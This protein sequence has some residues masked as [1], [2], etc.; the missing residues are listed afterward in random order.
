V[1]QQND[2]GGGGGRIK[3]GSRWDGLEVPGREVRRR[4]ES[5]GGVM[6][7]KGVGARRKKP[8]RDGDEANPS[9]EANARSAK[10]VK[11]RGVTKRLRAGGKAE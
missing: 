9:E 10:R 6:R 4:G 2:W 11:F 7:Q 3:E 8:I 1:L 5:G